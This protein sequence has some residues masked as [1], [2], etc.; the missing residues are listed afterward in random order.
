MLHWTG[1]IDRTDERVTHLTI[2]G[3]TANH[4]AKRHAIANAVRRFVRIDRHIDIDL[5]QTITNTARALRRNHDTRIRPITTEN[6]RNK[7]V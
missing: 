4:L 6:E 2:V 1:R 7:S 3:I 5:H